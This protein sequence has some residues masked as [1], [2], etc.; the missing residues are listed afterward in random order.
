MPDFKIL[1]TGGLGYL[2]GRIADSL[3]RNHPKSTIVLGTSRQ[4]SEVP[5]W[6]KPFQIV[7]LNILDPASIGKVVSSDFHAIIHLAALNEH[8]SFN[9]AKMAWETNALGTQSLLSDASEKQIQKFI[10]FSTFHVYGNYKGIITEDSP[11]RPHHPY[12][13]THRGAED[14]VRFFQHYK[15]MNTLTLRLSNGYGY[16]MDSGVNRWTLVFNDLCRQVMTSGKMVINS[17]GKQHRDFISLHDVAATVDYFLYAIP[18][19]W[20]DGL[21]NLGGGSSFSIADV[22]NKIAKVYERKYG[23]SIPIEIAG[24]DNGEIHSP[25][26]F[27]IDKLKKTGFHL[28]GKMEKEIEQTLLLCE[29][30]VN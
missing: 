29:N 22:A 28:A 24:N 5:D 17:S 21:F 20:A 1:I 8:D 10:Y 7:Q 30:F 26:H 14:I 19:K 4:I 16:P 18:D 25:V 6:A 11:T 12:A 15:G 2:G 23:K 3:K 9:D 27:S 13:A